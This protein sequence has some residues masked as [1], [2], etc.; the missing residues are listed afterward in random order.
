MVY[1]LLITFREGLEAALIIG[2]VLS[3]LRRADPRASARPVWLGAGLAGGLSLGAAVALEVLA[4]ELPGRWQDAIE[5]FAMLLAAAVLTWMLAW[6]RRQSA[7]IGHELRQRVDRALDAGT[8]FALGLLAFTAVG[9]E[10]LETALFLFG[11]S[12]RAESAA[13]YWTGAF[14][15]LALAA[16]VGAAIY[17]GAKSLPLRAFFDVSAVAL[18]VLAAGMIPNAL[19]ELHEAGF[20]AALGPR[21]WD[22]YT[23]LPDNYGPGRFLG[24][25]LGYDASPFAGQVIAYAAYLLIAVVVFIRAGRPVPRTPSPAGVTAA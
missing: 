10:G 8:G 7:T 17:R 11:G 6:M 9:R 20:I 23:L 2:I 25:L 21:L 24:T 13:L 15:G 18:V 1:A 3:Y 4:V 16:A 14:A 22:T 19:K 12:G 5:G